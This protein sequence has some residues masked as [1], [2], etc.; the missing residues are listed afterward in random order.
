M[1]YEKMWSAIAG[2]TIVML[3][4]WREKAPRVKG[5]LLFEACI[6]VRDVHHSKRTLMLSIALKNIPRI[7]VEK[8]IGHQPKWGRGILF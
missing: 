6:L 5:D 1:S 8:R 4:E 2:H 7:L 3:E